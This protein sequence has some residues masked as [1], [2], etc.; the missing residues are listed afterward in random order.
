MSKEIPYKLPLTN[1]IASA[2]APKTHH[3]PKTS[4]QNFVRQFAFFTNRC[5]YPKAMLVEIQGIK[6]WHFKHSPSQAIQSAP[7]KKHGLKNAY[8]PTP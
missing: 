3:Q 1:A 4:F 6:L 5:I 7:T 2:I 8:N